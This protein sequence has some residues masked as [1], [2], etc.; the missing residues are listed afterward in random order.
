[1][2][3]NEDIANALKDGFI[4]GTPI[5]EDKRNVTDGLFAIAASILALSEAV[6]QFTAHSIRKDKEQSP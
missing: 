5:L 6:D 1:M 4:S 2:T 3:I